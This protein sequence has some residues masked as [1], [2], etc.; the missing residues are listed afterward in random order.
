MKIKFNW[1][2]ALQIAFFIFTF[3]VSM[4]T[5]YFSFKLSNIF[6]KGGATSPTPTPNEY[7][8]AAPKPINDVVPEKGVYNVLFLG[9]G[10]VGHE[11]SLLTDSIIVVHVNTNTQKATLISVPRDLWVNGGHK[12]NASG[13]A[14]FQDEKPVIQSVTGL[15]INYFVAA[16]FSQFST[17]IDD[18]GGITVDNPT[19]L[20]DPFYPITGEE[21][22]T[23]GLTEAQVNDLKA[24]YSG[25]SLETQFTCRYEHLHF[26]KGLISLNGTQALKFVRSRHG[27]SDFARSARQLAV[28]IGIKNKLISFK[29]MGKLDDMIDTLTKSVRT[30]LDAGTIKSLIEVLGDPTAYDIKQIQLST[31]NVFLE[32]KSSGGAYVLEPKAGNLNFTE[33]KSYV[34]ANLN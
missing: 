20:D 17:I 4:F 21:N 16:D 3:F 19:T 28:L 10:G 26:D 25:Y 7:T 32:T 29:A 30:D 9:Y 8:M 1:R 27:D 33:V 18:L 5:T 23:C 34:K 6:V 12:I 11:G 22:N 13:I 24:K 31:Q 2:M 14:G 15:P